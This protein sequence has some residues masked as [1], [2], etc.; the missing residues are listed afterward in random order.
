MFWISN[1][2]DWIDCNLFGC[3]YSH[4]ASNALSCQALYNTPPI[5]CSSQCSQPMAI[6]AQLKH[7]LIPPGRVSRV[8]RASG[9]VWYT[10][11]IADLGFSTSASGQMGA[12]EEQNGGNDHSCCTF[13]YRLVSIFDLFVLLRDQFDR[14]NSVY[15]HWFLPLESMVVKVASSKPGDLHV[16]KRF[17][18]SIFLLE[19]DH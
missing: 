10:R 15:F 17:F 12:W 3:E 4:E 6:R 16:S 8:G 5:E 9:S 13:C 7:K 11:A 14:F 19:N 18:S 1:W 2:I